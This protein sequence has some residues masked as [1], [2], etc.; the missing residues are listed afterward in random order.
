MTIAELIQEFE[1]EAKTTRRVLE[2][3]PTDKLTWTPHTKSM[4]L[5]RLAMHLATAPAAISSWPI[6]DELRVQGRPVAAADVHR[7]DR[8]GTRRGRGTGEGE[9]AD[10]RRC[11]TRRL[12]VGDSR[13]QDVDDDAEGRAA[14]RA[15]DESHLPSSRPALG[16]S[17]TARRAGAA[18]LRPERRRESL[19]VTIGRRSVFRSARARTSCC[20]HWLWQRS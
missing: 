9:P 12:L 2:R 8:V 19:Q 13:R 16:V 15:A 1:A 6:A 18:D 3:V 10:D 5:G 4:S 14:A 7:S 20:A 17:S 11:G